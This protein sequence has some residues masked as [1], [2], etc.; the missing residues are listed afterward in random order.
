M[1][2]DIEKILRLPADLA[3]AI[4]K[5]LVHMAQDE[6]AACGWLPDEYRPSPIVVPDEVTGFDSDGNYHCTEPKK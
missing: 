6:L 3:V 5:G 4:G 1:C 2:E